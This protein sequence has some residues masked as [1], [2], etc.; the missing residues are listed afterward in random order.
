[1]IVK[2]RMEATSNTSSNTDTNTNTNTN[3]INITNIIIL[4]TYLHI[5]L[6]VFQ[7]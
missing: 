6:I 7:I 5:L 3:M 2:D 4:L 1:M